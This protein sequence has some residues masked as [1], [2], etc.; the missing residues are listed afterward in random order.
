MTNKSAYEEVSTKCIIDPMPGRCVVVRDGSVEKSGGI[1]IPDKAKQMP[2]TGTVVAV[3]DDDR[4]GLVGRRI[5]WGRYSGLVVQITGFPIY[6]ILTYEEILG[7][8]NTDNKM[9][10]D[11][12]AALNRE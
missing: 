3:G 12:L 7:F 8:L 11:N 2:T 5:V 1:W 6:D 4:H 10:M 9:D